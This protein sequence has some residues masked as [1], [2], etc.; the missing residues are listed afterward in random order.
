MITSRDAVHNT[1]LNIANAGQEHNAGQLNDKVVTDA[2]HEFTQL[3]L[4]A[5]E[6]VD[7]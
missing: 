7:V 4:G 1:K 6:V 5:L 2:N 3:D